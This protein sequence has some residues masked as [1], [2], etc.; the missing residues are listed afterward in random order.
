LALALMTCAQS[1]NRVVTTDTI[2]TNKVSGM[3]VALPWVAARHSFGDAAIVPLARVPGPFH[4]P[5]FQ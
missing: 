2:V 5:G 3:A 4:G 1:R